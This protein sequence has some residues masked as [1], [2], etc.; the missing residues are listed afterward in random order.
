MTWRMELPLTRPLSLNDR[1]S[2]WSEASAVAQLRGDVHVLA[3]HAKIPPCGRI[4]VQLHYVPPSA[5]R[6]DRD[7]LV[8]T[9]KPVL[10]GLV[11]DTDRY[12]TWSPPIIDPPSKGGPYLRRLY[13]IVREVATFNG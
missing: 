13:V 10:D 7:N 4:H 8:A 12:V 2:R 5:G 11:D 9:L 6:R 3:R 1:K